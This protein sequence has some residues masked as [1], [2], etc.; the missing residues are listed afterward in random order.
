MHNSDISG[1]YHPTKVIFLDDNKGFLD[2]LSLEFF[3]QKNVF[4]FTDPDK[5]LEAMEQNTENLLQYVFSMEEKGAEHDHGNI[6]GLE[7]SNL[8]KMIHDGSRFN[9]ASV[10]VV[11]YEMP[12]INGIEFCEQIIDKN[13]YKILLT[14]EADKDTAIAAFNDGTIDKFIHKNSPNLHQELKKTITGLI[15]KYFIDASQIIF[16][17]CGLSLRKILKNSKYKELFRR[18]KEESNSIEYYLADRAGSFLFLDKMGDPTW[19]IIN[20][21][22]TADEQAALLKGYSFSEA[23]IKKIL[24]REEILFLFSGYEY[25]ESIENWENYIFSAER[26]DDNYSYSIVKGHLTNSI[27][28]KRA[29]AFG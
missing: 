9:N 26:L 12:K 29:I 10:L 22:N 25:K 11:D 6:Q 18:V 14:A 21:Q 20:D 4:M 1:F 28:W 8:I 17:G 16:H 2:A 23:R 7:I 15:D 3:D 24:N 5:A 13:V 27:D 19:L